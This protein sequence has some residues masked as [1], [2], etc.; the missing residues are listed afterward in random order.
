ML[1]RL[2]LAAGGIDVLEVGQ[3]AVSPY[4]AFAPAIAESSFTIHM[5]IW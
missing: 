5:F 3:A 1:A 2:C 4:Q